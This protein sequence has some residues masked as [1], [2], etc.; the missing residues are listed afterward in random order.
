[1]LQAPQIVLDPIKYLVDEG[2]RRSLF[3]EAHTALKKA[4][5]RIQSSL[6]PLERQLLSDKI[7]TAGLSPFEQITM[8]GVDSRDSSILFR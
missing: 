1:M 8:S 7:S 5:E 2:T 6:S 3:T 4:M